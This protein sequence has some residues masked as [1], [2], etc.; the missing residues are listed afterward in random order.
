MDVLSRVKNLRACAAFISFF[1][2]WLLT[3]SDSFAEKITILYTG[4]THAALY[5]CSCP[6][7]PDGGVA[8]RM[9]KVKQLRGENPNVVLVD[10]GGFFAA[11]EQDEHSQDAQLDKA[12]TEINLKALELMGYDALSVGDDE[13]N[14]GR[15]YLSAQAKKSRIAFLS[16][17]LKLD[18]LKP[19]L[20]KKI[21]GLNIALIGLTNLQVKAKPDAL[22]AEDPYQALS[23]TISEAKKD[24]ADLV[25]ALSYL[26]EE[27]DKKLISRLEGIDV[28]V[29]AKS[30]DAQE[31]FSKIGNAFLVRASWQGRRLGKLDIELE[32]KKIKTAAALDIRL[33]DEVADHPELKKYVP[34][35]FEDSACRKEGMVGKC[36][37]PGK[38]SS[39]CA[40]EKPKQV[41][42]LV[43]QPKDAKI[44]H[45]DKFLGFLKKLFPGL[46]VNL[47]DSDSPDGKSWILKAQAKL[48]PVYL[49]AKDAD[50]ESGFKDIKDFSELKD[51]YYCLS[52]RL[53][54]GLIFIGRPRIANKLDVF[55][56]TKGNKGSEVLSLL[57]TL[58]DRHKELS[59]SL[60]YL[61]LETEEGFSAPGGL[62]ELEEDIRQVCVAKHQPDK[63]WDYASCRFKNQDSSWWDTC[64]EKSGINPAVVKKCAL[65]Q[66]GIDLLRENT[67]LNKELEMAVGPVFLVNNNEMHAARAF[68]RVEELEN[69]LGLSSP[70]KKDGN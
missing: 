5:H 55:M 36:L 59:L 50:T 60:H 6:V 10:A 22:E 17:N 69:L 7:Q 23:R 38:M 44:S 14:F 9:T 32:N 29:S 65:S 54:G 11:G 47:V 49:I 45:Q 48:F 70:A 25:V 57:K 61:A 63:L 30:Q 18:G 52:P 34:A 41:P 27:E 15:D 28:I 53:S 42:L 62:A 13:L 4:S 40:Y 21:S 2:L 19:Y 31:R 66:E 1:A 37:N 3:G 39:S 56:G 58:R 43:I 26:G 20:I 24:K 8:R 12:R 68:S 67:A 64:A 35:C 51:G 16:C 33:S 46:Q